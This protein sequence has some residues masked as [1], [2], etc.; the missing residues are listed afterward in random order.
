MN[1]TEAGLALRVAAAAALDGVLSRRLTAEDALAAALGSDRLESRDQAFA[2]QIVMTTLRRLGQIDAALAQYLAKPLP[3]KSGTSQAI[4]RTAAAQLLFLETPPY[5]AI[6]LAVEAARLDRN[7]RHFAG[8]VNAVLR[9]VSSERP[10]WSRAPEVPHINTPDWL[11][12]RW[13][14]QYGAGV[15]ERIAAAHL[16][17]PPTD[18]AV[19]GDGSAWARALYGT[20][21]LSDHV[22]LPSSAAAIPELAGFGSGEWWVQ[23][24]A[25]SLPVRLLGDVRDKKVA[26]LCAAPGGKT[27]QLASRGARVTALDSSQ[28]RLGRLRENLAR[29]RLDATVVC[30]DVMT[31]EPAGVFEAV[32]L[33][34]PCSATGTVRRHPEIPYTRSS[35]DIAQ[36][37]RLQAR[38]LRRAAGWVAPGGR[39]LFCTCSLEEEEGE[40][41]IE[42]FLA[43]TEDFVPWVEARS[44]AGL[45]ENLDVGPGMIRTYPHFMLNG[46]PGMDGFFACVLKRRP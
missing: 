4:L 17:E 39:L 29:T 31:F 22:R 23:D 32:V 5:A 2:M 9:K 35:R 13:V 45:P 6:N 38:L 46:A 7:A 43:E 19:K 24:V 12:Q 41:Q 36:L 34:A 42:H 44:A 14:R 20:L 30:A 21:L 33:D 25:A 28:S 11:W 10:R 15:A 8:L 40:R 37:A 26:D 1:S 27:L 3:R 16:E 18:I